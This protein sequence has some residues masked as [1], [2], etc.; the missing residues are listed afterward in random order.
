MNRDTMFVAVPAFAVAR[1]GFRDADAQRR[2]PII[3]VIVADDV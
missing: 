1:L 2:P 3:L